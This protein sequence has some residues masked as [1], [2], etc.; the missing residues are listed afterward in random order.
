MLPAFYK[1]QVKP[2]SKVRFEQAEQGFL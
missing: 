2:F 1:P